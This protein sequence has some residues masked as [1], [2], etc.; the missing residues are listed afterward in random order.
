MS[1]WILAPSATG[2]RASAR[3][4]NSS[5]PAAAL[6]SACITT[7]FRTTTVQLDFMRIRSTNSEA[8]HLS[9][10]DISSSSARGY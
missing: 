2:T 4:P 7:D 1:L 9:Y 3:I 5:T 6:A 10:R 8:V